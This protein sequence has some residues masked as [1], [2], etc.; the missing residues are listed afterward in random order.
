MKLVLFLILGSSQLSHAVPVSCEGICY[1]TEYSVQKMTSK[2]N[3]LEPEARSESIAACK[4]RNG[5]IIK[6]TCHLEYGLF[7]CETSC[8]FSGLTTSANLTASSLEGL[9]QKCDSYSSDTRITRLGS[10]SFC[11]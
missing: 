9:K 2:P 3:F 8:G 6:T 5:K 11:K 7:V 10:T 4:N 1:I